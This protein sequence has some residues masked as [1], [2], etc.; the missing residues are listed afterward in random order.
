M[1]RAARK[2]APFGF[3]MHRGRNSPELVGSFTPLLAAIV[4]ERTPMACSQLCHPH[5]AHDAGAGA[6]DDEDEGAPNPSGHMAIRD[7]VSLGVYL[8]A[9]LE[10]LVLPTCCCLW[11]ANATATT[12]AQTHCIH[13]ASLRAQ[14]SQERKS[15]FQCKHR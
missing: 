15:R 2:L 12:K 14:D 11:V 10:M 6:A 1:E 8:G 5:R 3:L 13:G 7:C 9:T 4:P